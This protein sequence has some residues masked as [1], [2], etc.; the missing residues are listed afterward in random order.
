MQPPQ[1]SPP[2]Y[3][4]VFTV[5][6]AGSGTVRGS[7]LNCGSTCSALYPFGVHETLVAN[8]DPGFHFVTWRGACATTTTC[9][10]WVGPTT[11]LVAVFD[12]DQAKAGQSQSQ[13]E[14]KSKGQDGTQRSGKVQLAARI[15]QFRQ[16]G[17]R[18]ARA[19]VV[20]LFVN[21]AAVLRVSLQRA[22]ARATWSFKLRPGPQTVRIPVPRAAGAGLG[23]LVLKLTDASGN[24]QTLKRS[25]RLRR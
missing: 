8:A 16:V 20:R 3:D 24:Q 15:M 13:A 23:R 22:R 4:I 17:H 2:G 10:L 7:R 19:L 18:R 25:L 14:S 12:A 1:A 21:E 6:H 11:S 9:S 5:T